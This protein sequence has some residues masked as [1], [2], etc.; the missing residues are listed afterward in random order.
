M[1]EVNLAL[2]MSG[3]QYSHEI[4]CLLMSILDERTAGLVNQIATWPDR[5]DRD[6]A[7][8]DWRRRADRAGALPPPLLIE[9][10]LA[11]A[12]R[13]RPGADDAPLRHCARSRRR[14]RSGRVRA[15]GIRLSIALVRRRGDFEKMVGVSPSSSGANFF[16]QPCRSGMRRRTRRP[17]QQFTNNPEVR[18]AAAGGNRAGAM[19]SREIACR[20]LARAQSIKRA[21]RDA[22]V[23][24]E[25]ARVHEGL[26]DAVFQMHQK[27]LA[28]PA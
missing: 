18:T 1:T 11:I 20:R 16:A 3:H 24:Y 10:Q 22:D 25:T 17:E 4:T 6:A 26:N 12:Q 2:T 27:T 9:G 23:L 28:S 14:H 13:S 5:R 8:R 15:D 7:S 21:F 19:R